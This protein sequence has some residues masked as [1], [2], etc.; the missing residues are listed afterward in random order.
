MLGI[1][2]STFS[3]Y[4]LKSYASHTV[5]TGEE[6]ITQLALPELD[7]SCKQKLKNLVEQIIEKQKDDPFYPYH[8]HEQKEIDKLVYKLYSLSDEDIRKVEIWYCR[9][10]QRLAEAQGTLA[11]VREKYADYLELCEQNLEQR[12]TDKPSNQNVKTSNLTTA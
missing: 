1:L 10:Y 5:E 9:R 11:E 3:R 4:L 2:T 7:T 6:V 8:L 12:I